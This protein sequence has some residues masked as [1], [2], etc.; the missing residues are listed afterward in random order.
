MRQYRFT[1]YDV[2]FQCRKRHEKARAAEKAA[3][4]AEKRYEFQCRK[5]HEKARAIV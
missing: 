2:E 4:E 5:R 3:K 1:L